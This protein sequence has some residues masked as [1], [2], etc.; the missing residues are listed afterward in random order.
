MDVK[1]IKLIDGVVGT[2]LCL[3][4]FSF[5]NKKFNVNKIL[6]IQLWGIGE[7]IL[8]LPAIKAF[9]NRYPKAEINL[10]CTSRNKDVYH[11]NTDIDNILVAKLNPFA[12]TMFILRNI[13]KYDLVIDFEE[14]L[15]ISSLIAYFAGRYRVGY[16][17]GVRAKL[18][19]KT[20]KYNDKQHVVQT[21]LDL[22]RLL[23][24]DLLAEKLIKVI[25]SKDDKDKV[26][27]LWDELGIKDNDY[28]VG[29]GAGA[30]ES[31]RS[32]IWPKDRFAALADK[33]YEQKKAKIFFFE[34]ATG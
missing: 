25:Y 7:T 32:R 33:L 28:V 17:H 16:S 5:K 30:A 3:G 8:T 13:K 23:D 18:Y 34:K 31:A 27:K 6:L 12:L 9:K 4:L 11:K 26:L 21:H 20:V 19:N 24:A 10:L 29:F 2:P 22:V 1:I 15:N 14:Y